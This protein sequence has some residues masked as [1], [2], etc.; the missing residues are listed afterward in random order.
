MTTTTT[1]PGRHFLPV[2]KVA[3]WL[4]QA[5]NYIVAGV[6]GLAVVGI[7][8][9]WIQ[10]NHDAALARLRDQI[11]KLYQP[12]YY[13]SR[14]NDLTWCAF[15]QGAWRTTGPLP[16]CSDSSKSYWDSEILPEQDVLRWRNVIKTV[17]QPSNLKME[18]YIKDNPS[19]LIT[20]ELTPKWDAFI[21][22]VESYKRII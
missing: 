17:F 18:G 7:I 12:F 19:L 21:R 6:I 5:A 13:E 2:R 16:T 10:T 1:P 3:R 11:A 20:D 8:Q 9:H 4:Y 22:H 14:T 15:V